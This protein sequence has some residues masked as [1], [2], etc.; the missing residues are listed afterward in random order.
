MNPEAGLGSDDDQAVETTAWV[1]YGVIPPLALPAS[2]QA[3]AAYLTEA[4][5]HVVYER[6][7][8]AR[9]VQRHGTLQDARRVAPAICRRLIDSPEVIEAWRSGRA[10]LYGVDAAPSIDSVISLLLNNHRAR[11]KRGAVVL[12]S[13][14]VAAHDVGMPAATIAWLNRAGRLV[15]T[16]RETNTLG[17]SN[18][19]AA[20]GL[21]LR[22]R[23][24]R[25]R[26]TWRAYVAELTRLATWC[27]ANGCGPLSDLTRR[28]L[29]A[30][31][32][33]LRQNGKAAATSAPSSGNALSAA[34]QA[35]SLAVV[36]SLYRYW[37]ATGYLL[38]NPA[39]SL[40][41]NARSRSEF[42]PSRFVARELL[43]ACDQ[44]VKPA[45][46]DVVHASVI[47]TRSDQDDQEKL[48]SLRRA[49]VWMLYRFSGVRV[50]ELVW[51]AGTNL[52]R[53]EV[54]GD[55]AWT[56]LVMGKGSKERAI[57]LPR[58]C[59]DIL[60]RYRRARGLPARPNALE[61]LPLIHGEKGGSLGAH[62][63]YSVIKAVMNEVAE[64]R[65][66]SDPAG[67]AMLRAASPHWLRHAYAR[68]LVVDHNVPLPSAQALLGHASVQTTAAYA[69]TDQSKLREFVDA[70]FEHS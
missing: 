45:E 9:L 18:D 3:V 12:A 15:N 19:Y 14:D 4:L 67:A 66:A 46:S 8:W 55:D 47:A 54:E 43:E 49:V 5:G 63:L 60:R 26:H 40:S 11:F 64:A 16:Q 65:A 1:D 31:R 32:E 70:G 6:W 61:Q 59:D 29:L 68:T 44:W 17:V 20:L 42:A 10:K 38:G 58:L 39:A 25:S 51:D 13:G 50:G 34:S 7:T 41:P 2:A 69:K 57:P 62:G 30:Y 23:A 53:L 24:A 37:H 48:R 52:P 21:F 28:D 22:E 33:G 36:A 27:V 56:L 35:R